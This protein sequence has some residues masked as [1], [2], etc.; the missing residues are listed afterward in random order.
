MPRPRRARPCRVVA[1]RFLLLSLLVACGGSAATPDAPRGDA[2]P[3]AD[4]SNGSAADGTPTRMPCTSNFGSALSTTFGRL[5]GYLVA[6]VPPGTGG[7]NADRGHVHLQV[8]VNGAIYDIA[9]DVGSGSQQDVHTT[10]RDLPLPGPAWS[11][12]W[13]TGVSNSY[14]AMGVHSGDL[15]LEDNAQLTSDVMNDLATVNHISVYATGYGPDGAHLVHY[16]GSQD[17]GLLVTEPLSNPAH[18]RLFS[19]TTQSF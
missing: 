13:H 17:D 12:G 19:F 14:V 10:T 3:P 8:K 7:C 2:R 1:V 5:D 15:Q 16:N 6:I 4:G 11:E 18:A 9:V